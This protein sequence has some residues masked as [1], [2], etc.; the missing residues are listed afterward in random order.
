MRKESEDSLFNKLGVGK[1]A[2]Q[3]SCY[4]AQMQ[5]SWYA[6]RSAEVPKL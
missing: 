2:L 6:G 4:I 5:V 3:E 1:G